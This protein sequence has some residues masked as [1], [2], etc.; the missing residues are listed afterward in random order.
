MQPTWS[1]LFPLLLE[2]LEITLQVAALSAVVSL[3]IA[4]A[5]GLCRLSKW[6]VVRGAATVYVEFFRG[7]S[8]LVLMFWIYFALPFV[9]IN[10]PKLAAA[11]LAIGL[12]YGAYG[13]EIVRSSIL[14][15]PKGQWEAAI[16][17]NMSPMQ[18]MW[19]I[20]FPQAFIRMLPPLGNLL[21][22][23]IKA[24]SLVYFI[25]LSDLTYQAM[26]LRNNF[27]TWTPQ[28]FGLLLVIYFVLSCCVSLI[29]RFAERR[30]A[31]WRS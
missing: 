19:R 8:L 27:L 5:A 6:A 24:T 15:V 3:A 20:V 16:A 13:S 17:L 25:T 14:A 7:V 18:R 11:V 26:I 29:V 30:L 22:E 4:V 12:N 1:A 23:L 21:I 28:I 10:L 31:A 2:G 9:G